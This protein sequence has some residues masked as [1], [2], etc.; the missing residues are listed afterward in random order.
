MEQNELRAQ[1]ISLERKVELLINKYQ[2]VNKE[3]K[4]L[5]LENVSLKTIIEEKEEQI[6]SFQNTIKISKI[7]ESI[8]TKENNSLELKNRVNEYIIEIDK[9][10]AHLSK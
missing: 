7:V 3:M 8:N 2:Q 5:Q 1:L 6:N 9:C 10:I 4:Q